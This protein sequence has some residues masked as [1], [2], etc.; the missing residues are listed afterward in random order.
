MSD[1]QGLSIFDSGR[2]SAAASPRPT[3]PP[4]GGDLPVVRRGG[5]DRAAVDARIQEQQAALTTA[6]RAAADA[7]RRVS[8]LESQVAELRTQMAE[9]GEPTYAGLGGRAASL[10][11]LAED[12]ADEVL[13]RARAQ[14]DETLTHAQ[15]EAEALRAAAAKEIDDVKTVHLRDLEDQRAGS[16]PPPRMSEPPQRHR[17]RTCSPA[18]SGS[19]TRSGSLPSRRRRACAPLPSARARRRVQRRSVRCPRPAES[20]PWSGND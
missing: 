6:E 9:V 12:Q 10:L 1:Q 16:R 19:P 17:P 3:A 20:W 14:A 2:G 15:R 18:R 8:E 4:D 7:R 11:S 13:S 5:Y